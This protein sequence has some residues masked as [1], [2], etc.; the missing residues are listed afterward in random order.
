MHK[1]ERWIDDPADTTGN[2]KIR[3]AKGARLVV[4]VDEM[5]SY[6]W[7]A[8]EDHATEMLGR[9]RIIVGRNELV[10]V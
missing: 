8:C 3:C 4:I 2:H 10:S 7:W 5:P 6:A 1:C 9:G